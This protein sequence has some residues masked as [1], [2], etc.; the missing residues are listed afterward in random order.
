MSIWTN[1]TFT[2]FYF[3]KTLGHFI[4]GVYKVLRFA[5]GH[6]KNMGHGKI[7]HVSNPGEILS[8]LAFE[9]LTIGLIKYITF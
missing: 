7:I 5:H 6:W 2:I 1:Y 9:T 8:H 3:V 4:A